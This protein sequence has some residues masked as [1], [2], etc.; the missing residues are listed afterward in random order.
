MLHAVVMA[1]GSGTR[2]WPQSRT[3]LP[4]QFLRLF[5]EETLL[6]ATLSRVAAWIPPERAWVVTNQAHAAQTQRQL[7]ALPP[8]NILQ[9]P[10]GRNTAPCIGLA[11]L[12]VAARDPE[13]IMLV[14]PAD[15]F[16]PDAGAFRQ[17]VER[18]V[19]IV[20]DDPA[21]LLLFGV[22]PTYPCVS[23]GYIERGEPLPGKAA[24]AWRVASFREKPDRA[25]AEQFLAAGR[26]YWNSGI[27][28]WKAATILKALERFEPSIFKS[29]VRLEPSVG[30]DGWEAALAAE[31][32]AMKGISIDYAVLER[33]DNVCVLEAPFEWDDVGSWQALA[34]RRGTDATGN[35]VEGPFCGIGSSGC[36]ISTTPDHLVATIGLSDCVIVHTP[37]A[38]LVARTDDEEGIRKLVQLL[39]ERGHDRF[40]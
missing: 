13:G 35:T 23:F 11:A 34:R 24:G 18:A 14:M 21:A 30:T 15:H 6:A 28:V 26:F 39:R 37:D 31:F 27:F 12:Q 9:E 32:P 16:V 17:A 29:L 38:T 10:C 8:S 25:Q 36:I 2:F 7:P 22:R 3:G 40:L 19:S 4:K 1:G 20:T 33:A 5:G